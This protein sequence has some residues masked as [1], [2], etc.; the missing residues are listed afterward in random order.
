MIVYGRLRGIG[1]R[2]GSRASGA[3][4]HGQGTIR[5]PMQI[6]MHWTSHW[7]SRC[8]RSGARLGCNAKS[9]A[10]SNALEDAWAKGKHFGY[11]IVFGTS[12]IRRHGSPKLYHCFL[13]ESLNA[14]L[15]QIAVFCHRL[16]FHHR[17]FRLVDLQSRLKRTDFAG[18][19]GWLPLVAGTLLL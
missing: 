6:P 18:P 9:S 5:I 19:S 11:K 2:I 17:V 8:G 12:R 10:T 15:R 3:H 4:A 14:T 16:T 13:D 1:I 7:I